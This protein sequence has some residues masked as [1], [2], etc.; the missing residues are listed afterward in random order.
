MLNQS[1][2]EDPILIDKVKAKS[3]SGL[4]LEDDGGNGIEIED[5]GKV[6]FSAGQLGFPATQ[7]P[8]ADANTLDDYE[9][10][11]YTATVICSLSGSYVLNSSEDTLAYTKIGRVCHVQGRIE[12]TNED[13]PDGTLRVLLP[14]L[15]GTLA[16]E[17]DQH[18][19]AI[20]LRNHSDGGIENPYISI[21]E[22]VNYGN[23]INVTDTGTIEAITHARVDTDFFIY[24]NFFYITA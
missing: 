15:S 23:L 21:L 2:I 5:G 14:F 8:S 11:T 3:G 1:N 6:L 4:L 7:N 13:S 17:A 22:S 18:C 19:T 20:L 10:G 16:K 12:I 24:L 9:E